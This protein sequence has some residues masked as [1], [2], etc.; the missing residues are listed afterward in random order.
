MQ[1][2]VCIYNEVID[3]VRGVYNVFKLEHKANIAAGTSEKAK[4][5]DEHILVLDQ[6]IAQEKLK[7]EDR[8]KNKDDVDPLLE[9]SEKFDLL[10]EIMRM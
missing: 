3:S 7:K 9:K 2:R 10:S 8:K 4:E 1:D 5:V 6:I